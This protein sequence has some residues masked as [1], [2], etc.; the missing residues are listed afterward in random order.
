MFQ[1]KSE[2]KHQPSIG[3]A[4][5]RQF[6]RS[7]ELLVECRAPK[8][9]RNLKLMRNFG[10]FVHGCRISQN[11]FQPRRNARRWMTLVAAENISSH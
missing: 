5:D 11:E 8:I 3:M 1:K 6:G 2:G 7:L 4:R 9:S 10:F